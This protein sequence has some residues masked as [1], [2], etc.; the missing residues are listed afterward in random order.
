MDKF[1]DD[2]ES[3]YFG[4]IISNNVP[5][6]VLLLKSGRFVKAMQF[7]AVTNMLKCEKHSRRYISSLMSGPSAFAHLDLSIF[8]IGD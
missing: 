6:F 1:R 4:F 5:K 2:P 3:K 8:I 7:S